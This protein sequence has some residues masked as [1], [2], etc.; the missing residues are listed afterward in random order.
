MPDAAALDKQIVNASITNAALELLPES[1]A[2]M[3]ILPLQVRLVYQIGKAYGYDLD[4]GHI[5]EFIAT[6]GVG[7]TGQ[8]LEQFGRKLLGGLLGAVLG[9]VGRG[10]GHQTASSGMSFA[11]TWA[12][13]QLAKQYYGGGRTLDAAKLKAAF[14]PLLEQG[15][16]LIGRYGGEIAERA[17]G[18]STCATCRR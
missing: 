1:L 10:V 9:G 3:A 12:L 15:Q 17:R 6:L 11:T 13:G 8:Y 14:A 4:Q 5:K 7:L 2:S 18:R 16:G